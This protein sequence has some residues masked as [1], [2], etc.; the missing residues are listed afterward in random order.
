MPKKQLAHVKGEV[1]KWARESMNFDITEIAEHLKIDT[2]RLVDWENGTTQPTIPQLRKIATLYKRPL[3]AF[4]L[5]EPPR[6][7]HV[8]HDFRQV[9]GQPAP[10]LSPELITEIRA[11]Q[12]R[13]NLAIDLAEEII[14]PPETLIGLVSLRDNKELVAK[15]ARGLLGISLSM[16]KKWKTPYDA[17]NGWKIAMEAL[18]VLVFHFSGVEVEEVRGFAISKQ[19]FPVIGIN[20][21]DSPYGRVFTLIHELGHLLLNKGGISDLKEYAYGQSANQKIE[22][23]C[24]FLAGS[25]L[26]PR[27]DLLQQPDVKHATTSTEWKNPQLQHLANLYG[28]SKEVILRRL[29]IVGKTNKDFFESKRKEFLAQIYATGKPG[30]FMTVPRKIIRAAGQPFL[31]IILS[32]YNRQAITTSDLAEYLGARLKHLPAI[33]HQLYGTNALSGG[34]H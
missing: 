3:A 7:F 15:K 6:D 33:E 34:K 25:V 23:F 1:L 22:I 14:E 28:V 4:F 18:G 13:R 2:Q 12:F 21:K 10:A 5:P 11:A 29:L 20:G 32:A 16:Q 30:G 8:P 17:L 27:E 19:P 31:R 26:V 24:N 9:F